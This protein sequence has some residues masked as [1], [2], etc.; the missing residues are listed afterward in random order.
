M[1]FAICAI[2]VEPKKLSLATSLSMQ[3]NTSEH[4]FPPTKIEESS[5][6]AERFYFFNE[7][8]VT[9]FIATNV[10]VGFQCG[11]EISTE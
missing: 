5:Q 7:L 8:I 6:Q 9:S 2:P 3:L 11:S 1:F 4:T 10:I